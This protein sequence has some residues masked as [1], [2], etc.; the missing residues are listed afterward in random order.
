MLQRVIKK[1]RIGLY[2]AG[3][4]AYWDQFPGMYERLKSYGKFIE[5]KLAQWG[6][7]FNYGIVDDE[8]AGIKAGEWF[9]T[10]NTDIVFAHCGTYFTSSSILPIH[11]LCKSP[12]VFLNL[13]PTA[14]ME[15]SKTG[16]AEWLCNCSACPAPEAANAF[17]RAGLKFRIVNGLLGMNHSY[18]GS[19]ADEN[20]EN[21]DEAKKAWEQIRQWVMAAMVKRNLMGSRFGYL[22][23]AYCGMLDMYSDFTMIQAQTGVITKIIEMCDFNSFLGQVTDAEIKY[24]TDQIN[25]FFVI[26]GDSPSDPIACKPTEEELLWSAKIAAAQERMVK[27]YGLDAITYYYHGA[28]GNLYERIQGGFI[29]GHSL[30]T[31]AGIPCSGEGDM[32]TAIAMKICDLLGRGGSYSEIIAVDYHEKSIILGHDGPFHISI[33]EGKPI[34]RGMKLYHGKR[35]TGI[36]VEA[37][38]IPGKVTTLGMT[39]TEKGKLKLISGEGEAIKSQILLI[40]NTETHVRFHSEPDEYMTKWFSEA[41]THHFALS[42]GHNAEQFGKVADLLNIQFSVL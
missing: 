39:Q 22:G 31:A 11:Q 2:T 41:P 32:K 9:N 5:S 25:D 15:Y 42:I 36:S 21:A 7:V 4:K 37:N 14:R 3:L 19:I 17:E 30:L 35:G 18:P 6:E 24:Q 13:Q 33:S 28:D 8:S 38:V 27:E 40:G 20:T 23:G 34:L 16:T 12:V 29:V 10:K 1:P 26:E